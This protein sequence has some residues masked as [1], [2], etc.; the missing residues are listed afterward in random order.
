MKR[1]G[2][3]CRNAP[4]KALIGLLYSIFLLVIVFACGCVYAGKV[5]NDIPKQIYVVCNQETTLDLK[6]P[7]TGNAGSEVDFSKPVTFRG[8][9][10]GDYEL[11]LKLFGVIT[12]PSVN[13]SVVDQ[14]YLYPGGFPVGLY[15][16]TNGVYV[17]ELGEI[18]DAQN[19]VVNPCNGVLEPGDYITAVDGNEISYKT[20]LNK[21][22]Q[23]KCN[24]SIQLTVVRNGKYI[25][26][27]VTPVFTAEGDYKIGVWVKDDAQGIGTV[28]YIDENNEFGALGHGISDA[29]TGNTLEIQSG[30]LYK[31]KIISIVKGSDGTPGEFIGTIDYRVS[32]KLGDIADNSRCGIF[33]SLSSDVVQSYG[34]ER[35]AVGFSHDVHKGKAYIRMYTE[36]EFKDYEVK[37]TDLS[38]NSDKNITF[39]VTSKELLELT[40]GVVQGMS[41]CPLIQDGKIVGAVTH[42][43]VD[44]P[45][46][47]YGIFIEN[48][49]QQ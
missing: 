1:S 38:Y 2:N 10:V 3:S 31:T 40:N 21:Y 13:V 9:T 41:G 11:K 29:Q 35:M 34:L 24:E 20:E 39:K 33:G 4:G 12:L 14:Q 36:G 18:K 49:L 6:V 16:K 45:T 43:F 17:V 8:D 26:T 5:C 32:N 7:V 23:K 47:G 42:V 28:T 46:N 15:L 44:D 25:E 48:M 19:N 22:I 27:E 37:I 30:E